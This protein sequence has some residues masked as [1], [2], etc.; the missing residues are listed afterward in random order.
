MAPSSLMQLCTVHRDLYAVFANETG[1]PE[2]RPIVALAVYEFGQNPEMRATTGLV[3]GDRLDPADGE[4]HFVAYSYTC[5]ATEWCAR[6]KK[7]RE[8][9]NAA[10]KR[11]EADAKKP[12][13]ILP[14]SARPVAARFIPKSVN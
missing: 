6:C 2:F 7:K 11:A 12:Q 9:V 4:V 3:A 1:E 5:E 8:Q 14:D 13:I 10:I